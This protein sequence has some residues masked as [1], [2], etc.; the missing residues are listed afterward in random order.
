MID[1]AEPKLSP[2]SLQ[3]LQTVIARLA[4]L[5]HRP[6]PSARLA[7]MHPRQAFAPRLVRSDGRLETVDEAALDFIV[8]DRD[9]ERSSIDG[10]LKPLTEQLSSEGVILLRK[11]RRRKPWFGPPWRRREADRYG[12]HS[13]GGADRDEQALRCLRLY[14]I[15]FEADVVTGQEKWLAAS[16]SPFRDLRPRDH[17]GRVSRDF[18]AWGAFWPVAAGFPGLAR[19]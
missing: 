11:A 1:V 3:R 13:G 15:E 14:V 6:T 9:P 8:I 18:L 4:A 12:P 17:I 7:L 2:R 10:D 16:P 5:R 19:A